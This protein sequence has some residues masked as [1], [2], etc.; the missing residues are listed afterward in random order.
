MA[1]SFKLFVAT[2]VQDDEEGGIEKPHDNTG[3]GLAMLFF[4]I[5]PHTD[6]GVRDERHIKCQIT[7][8]S[9]KICCEI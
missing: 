5:P 8:S 3:R 2:S 4:N 1:I 7:V 9:Q 6:H